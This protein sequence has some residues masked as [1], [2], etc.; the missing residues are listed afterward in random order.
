MLLRD[1]QVG[2]LSPRSRASRTTQLH[3]SAEGRYKDSSALCR[4]EGE[5]QEGREDRGDE[6]K[7]RTTEGRY[8]DCSAL[9]RLWGER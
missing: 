1:C 3:S 5:G 9:C 6:R 4:G 7:G 2:K 8:R